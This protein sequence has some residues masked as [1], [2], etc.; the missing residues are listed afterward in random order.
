MEI[1]NQLLKESLVMESKELNAIRGIIREEIEGMGV[2]QDTLMTNK[3]C[4]QHLSL[5][6]TAFAKIVEQLP[7]V[8]VGDRC[9]KN[10][11]FFKS[12]VNLFI[13]AQSRI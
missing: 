12:K 11:R 13:E 4:M 5:Q 2:A 9:P 8:Y 10:R 3:E 1:S 7:C 6:R